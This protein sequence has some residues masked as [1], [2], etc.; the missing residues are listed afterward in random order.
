MCYIPQMSEA[1][2]LL[3]VPESWETLRRVLLHLRMCLKLCYLLS[4]EY[5]FLSITIQKTW[6]NNF[7]RSFN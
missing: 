6:S 2:K 5:N 7:L 1:A 3:E 4:D